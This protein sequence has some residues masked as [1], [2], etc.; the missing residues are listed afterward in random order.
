M[1]HVQ[2][3]EVLLPLKHSAKQ[4]LSG[5]FLERTET[6]VAPV[7]QTRVEKSMCDKIVLNSPSGAKEVEG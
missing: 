6:L 3:N 2:K 7:I 1:E 5:K 4:G